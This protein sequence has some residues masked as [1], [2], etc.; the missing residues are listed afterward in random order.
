MEAPKK[1]AHFFNLF[2][3][4]RLKAF[5]PQRKGQRRGNQPLGPSNLSVKASISPP[6]KIFW[7]FG[8]PSLL[9]RSTP[10]AMSDG[11]HLQA[12]LRLKAAQAS[13]AKGLQSLRVAT[14]AHGNGAPLEE[15]ESFVTAEVALPSLAK[16]G[17]WSWVRASCLVPLASGPGQLRGHTSHAPFVLALDRRRQLLWPR[18][19]HCPR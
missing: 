2:E 15:G 18:R 10:F 3:K 1:Q 17:T 12:R 4:V 16:G 5:L 14:T 8:Y 11:N 9:C 13:L 7:L 6:P 19:R